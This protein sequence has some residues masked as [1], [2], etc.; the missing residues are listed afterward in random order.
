[1]QFDALAISQGV[2]ATKQSRAIFLKSTSGFPVPSASRR[3][4]LGLILCG[5]LS[6]RFALQMYLSAIRGHRTGGTESHKRLAL[7]YKLMESRLFSTS[8]TF[9]KEQVGVDT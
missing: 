7:A 2:N 1:M 9:R 3:A 5:V 6:Y 8:E 4:G